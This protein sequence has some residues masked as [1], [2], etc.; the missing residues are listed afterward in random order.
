MRVPPRRICSRAKAACRR[1]TEWCGL[2][3]LSLI[4]HGAHAL[5]GRRKHC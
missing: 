4:Y 2:A 1:A 5:L 3:I